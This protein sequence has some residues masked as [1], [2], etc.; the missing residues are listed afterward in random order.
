[1]VIWNYPRF[2]AHDP[3]ASVEPAAEPAEEVQEG[4]DMHV[5]EDAV[6]GDA[7]MELVDE[8]GDGGAS[9]G[10]AGQGEDRAR[11]E[12]GPHRAI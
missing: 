7:A 2:H 6:I 10:D 12:N 5:A 1:M 8:E 11:G 4:Y 9:P 3:A